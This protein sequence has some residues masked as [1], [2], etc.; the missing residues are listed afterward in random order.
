MDTEDKVGKDS[1][2]KKR[3]TKST[4]QRKSQSES[5]GKKIQKPR[6]K[7]KAVDSPP[8]PNFEAGVSFSEGDSGTSGSSRTSGEDVLT[9]ND[10]FLVIPLSGG[11]GGN[12]LGMPEISIEDAQGYP[13]G[14]GGAFGK[15]L[16]RRSTI[17][18]SASQ[19]GQGTSSFRERKPSPT[20]L[21]LKTAK[22]E[23]QKYLDENEDLK[24]K[25]L[26]IK[27]QILLTDLDVASKA[28]ILKKL[29]DV[30]NNK[31]SFDSN[32]FQLW[33][34]DILRLPMNKIRPL[35][36]TIESGPVEVRQFLEKARKKLDNAI[37]GQ[38]NAKEEIMDYIARMISNPNSRGN[39]LALLGNKG[40]GKTRLVRK[41]LSE[42]LDRPFHV[43]NLGGL[44]DPQVLEGH[45]PSYSGAVYGR[46]AQILISSQCSNPIIYLDEIDKVTSNAS[47]KAA[48]VHRV[49]THVLDEEQNHEFY[50]EYFSGIKI[51]L[52]KV[53]FI[54]S[55]N[56]IEDVD[57]ILRDRLKI[58]KV[59]DLDMP[60][61]LVIVKDYIL[62][63]LCKDI[64]FPEDLIVFTDD[65]IR[66]II[67]M[68]TDEEEG[69][70][71][72]KKNIETI[73]QRLNTQRITSLGIF[74][75]GKEKGSIKITESLVNDLLKGYETLSKFPTH[76]YN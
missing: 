9:T 59:K 5:F 64:G 33:V 56:N 32:K 41:G 10:A 34:K 69:C 71:Q 55:L 14:D 63:E 45:S 4:T 70:R 1:S 30:Q 40:V 8:Y 49:L 44:Q 3:K 66:Y 62:P 75:K 47:E 53:L 11:V 39:V 52:S 73:L 29:E 21:K 48:Q 51:D 72:L 12:C 25:N 23:L 27:D 28:L 31:S 24:I 60:T 67:Q 18:S 13:I 68:K 19:F 46:F 16:S 61:K 17:S 74:E 2:S 7:Q 37:A 15:R 20:T 57:P 6:K 54:A 76:L 50:D 65:V 42:A 26:P 22:E 38:D 36:V 43:I 35:P 58:I